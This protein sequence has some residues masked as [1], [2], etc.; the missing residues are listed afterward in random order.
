MK[1]YS[2]SALLQPTPSWKN[3]L[4]VHP[5]KTST[6]RQPSAIRSLKNNKTPG[7]DSIPAELL[8]KG[9]YFCTRMLHQYITEVWDHE[10]VPQQWRD[11]NIV[12]I[13]KNKGDK[14][15][16]GNSRGISLLAV[17]GKVLATVM[18]TGWRTT[19][20]RNC[21]RSVD[22]ERTGVWLT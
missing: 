12:T 18:L 1:H 22:S 5:F 11:A 8:K 15:I 9:G 20:Q 10:I 13:Y 6:I 19:S 14:S 3:C 7:A 4:S 17:A 2:I 21:C 16:C